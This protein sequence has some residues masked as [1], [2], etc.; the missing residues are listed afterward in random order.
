M[1]Y[2]HAVS[3]SSPNFR[4]KSKPS[5]NLVA[6]RADQKGTNATCFLSAGVFLGLLFSLQEASTSLQNIRKRY[7]ITWHYSPLAPL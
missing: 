4:L 7:L 2:Y 1:M 5:K 3:L 6:S